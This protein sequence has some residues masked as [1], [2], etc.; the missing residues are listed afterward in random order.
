MHA[1]SDG[2]QNIEVNA[3]VVLAVMQTVPAVPAESVATVFAGRH[4]AVCRAP[5]GRA[6]GTCPLRAILHAGDT[7]SARM[8]ARAPCIHDGLAEVIVLGGR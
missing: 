8:L 1:D 5:A 6:P 7:P 4:R 3:H 2:T